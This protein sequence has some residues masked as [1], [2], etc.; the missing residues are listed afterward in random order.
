MTPGIS[1]CLVLHNHQP[2]GNF[3]WVIR[4]LWE[5]AY[6]PMLKALEARPSFRAGLHYS[7]PLLDWIEEEEPSA[8]PRIRALAEREQV[9]LLGSGLTEPI[10][11]SLPLR[12]RHTQLVRM[13]DRVES[14]FGR[15]PAGAWLTE[16]VWEPDLASDLAR[17][18]YAYTIVDDN[19]LRSAQV[20]REGQWGTWS[21]DDQG[22]RL[23]LFASEQGLRYAMPWATVEETIAHLRANATPERSR[24]GLMGDDGEKFGG[25]P[26]THE[27]CWSTNGWMQQFFDAV[28]QNAAWIQPVRPADWLAAHPPLG[29]VY[30]PT[31][32]Y[33][34]MTEWAL[35]PDEAPVFHDLLA[36]AR[37]RNRP[38]YKF[39]F[40][41]F[42]RA[43]QARYREI[44][45]LHKQMLRVSD[46]VERMAQGQARD[47]ALEHLFRGQSNDVY[48]HGLFGGIYLVH[49]RMA[50]LA[51]LIAAQDLAEGGRPQ[52]VQA[53]LDLDGVDEV[54]LGAHGQRLVVDVAEGAGIG[55]WD[56]FASRLAMGSSM[57]RRP[58]S[59]H[60]RLRQHFLDLA[61]RGEKP[62]A[63][64][65]A[66]IE[67][68]AAGVADDSGNAAKA[69]AG[70]G[71]G[72]AADTTTDEAIV[73]LDE[74]LE[75]LLVYDRHEQRGALVTLRDLAMS[76]ALGASEL[77]RLLDEDLGDFTD[78]CHEL[79]ELSDGA[80]T[81]RREGS[82]R[83]AA[84]HDQGPC[85]LLVTKRFEL[86]G[87]RR[88]PALNVQ[89]EL[90]NAESIPQAFEVDLSFA[91]NAAGGGHNPDAYYR[92]MVGGE[93]FSAPHDGSGDLMGAAAVSFGNRY[94]G[95]HV[96]TELSRPGRIT[97]F[98]IET[99]SKSEGGYERVYQS[100]SLHVRWP[101]ALPAGGTERLAVTFRAQQT[102]D[103][104]AEEQERDAGRGAPGAEDLEAGAISAGAP[105]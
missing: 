87:T 15:R 62:V 102:R 29:R 40:G 60:A 35:P 53:D 105:H 27:L 100:S 88:D 85:R 47:R 6:E 72:D 3:G 17:A 93:A 37:R 30:V 55:A 104:L 83:G 13:A 51:E 94:V 11:A 79:V 74:G 90:T 92:W 24:I 18:G 99:V 41:G 7:G 4:D 12:D 21:T 1:L 39:L 69:P 28:E 84:D 98:P 52:T 56:L 66:P 89:L 103:L 16:R 45:D 2:V 19:H 63:V 38:A 23:T 9:E 8:I 14:L 101:V 95:V 73:L 59:Y 33:A 78:T 49:L 70:E 67:G 97:W 10:L 76:E 81:V 96:E 61:E 20:P 57:R 91:W 22:L 36:E 86:S 42:W 5:R 48:W 32:S 31:S 34:E 68:G 75:D 25:W 64:R 82:V 44:N 46:A 54:Q 58:E 77:A 71:T 80:L 65:A 26:G 50:V 43:F